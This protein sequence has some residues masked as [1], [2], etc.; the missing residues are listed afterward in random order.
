[1]RRLGGWLAS[2]CRPRNL[3]GAALIGLSAWVV[4]IGL[5][6]VGP[7]HSVAIET[8]PVSES[9]GPSANDRTVT[10][11]VS[12]MMK[13]EHLSKHPMDDEISRRALDL[14]L[15]SIDGRKL[16]FY[17]SDV[18]EFHLRRNDL[19]DMINAGD[20]SFAYTVFN[21]F[22]KRVD[23]RMVTINQL[24]AANQFDFNA[25]DVL[26]S[27][28]DKL[29]YPKNPEEAKQRWLKQLKYD[30]LV[31]KA[32]KANKEDITKRLKRRYESI[33]KRMHQTDSNELLEMFL[34]AITSSFDP[35]STYMAPV[36]SKNFEI[37]IGLQLEG[38][39]AQLK[40][41]DGYTV[42]D[43]LIPGG[44]ADKNGQ[45]KAGDRVVSVGQGDDG[46]VVDVAEM[47]LNDV[48]DL[49]RG[50]AG[51]VV[52]LGVVTE[53]GEP[54]TIKITRAKIELKDQEARG[55]IIED[56]RKADGSPFK[57]GVIDLP[58]FYMDMKGAREG[59]EDFKSCTRDV[60]RII[61]DFNKKGVDALVLDLRKNGGGSLTEAI[62]LTGL[63]I[64]QGPVLQVK[65]PD[66]RVQQYDDTDRGIA[67]RGPLVV[68]ISKFS[69]SASEI[70]A[71]AIQDY[72]RGLII[73]D[74]STHGKGTVQTMM[75]LGPQL[76]RIANPPD[77]GSLKLTVQQFYRP[78]GDSTQ[79]RGV[80]AD[81]VLP[82]LTD[83]YDVSESDLDYPVAFDKVPAVP[84]RKHDAVSANTVSML[85]ELSTQRIERSPEFAKLQ[86]N[87]KRYEE[88]KA[89]K[90]V[91]LN[92][93]K[94]NA[95]REE[96]DADKEEEKTFEEHDRGSPEVFKR[97]FYD[98]EVLAITL[99]YLRLLGKDK[100]A[101][102]GG[103]PAIR[104]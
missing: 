1:M 67:W 64:E 78:N 2:A 29:T 20:V 7:R 83:H 47:K 102:A 70:L 82:S 8:R 34:T 60:R 75:D 73:G 91:P 58:S 33:A 100:V 19:D 25:D 4:G 40:M 32:D 17:Q 53:G 89:K 38:I 88:Q 10:R 44:P 21:R 80:L 104:N 48:V 56:G 12:M 77:L 15:K 23:E 81:V 55:T 65:D 57:L 42:I 79:Q 3:V 95:R 99:D 11:L 97:D 69:A 94:F 54:K 36:S 98:N 18:D 84:F 96:F 87:I 68:M 62:S 59:N 39:G 6:P 50:R 16:Y 74:S 46:Q 76:F 28:V 30:T 27:D 103:A 63:F 51:T 9:S 85:K 90:E 66:G 71:G 24:L 52:K 49:I 41:T 92:E 43:K 5:V 72:R 45:L 101:N 13:R 61:D 93:A 35:H 22:L 31:L 86:K 37:V 26:V 14:F